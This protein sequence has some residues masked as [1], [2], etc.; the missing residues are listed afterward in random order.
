MIGVCLAG[1]TGWAGSA[2][3]AGIERAPDLELRS[4]VARSSAGEALPGGGRIH[5]DVAAALAAAPVDV[6]IDYTGP[7]AVEGNARAALEAGAG[8]V[9]GSSGL[10]DDT[11]ADLDRLA[12]SRGVGIIASGNFSM[13]AAVMTHAALLAAERVEHFELVE[14]FHDTKPDAPSGSAR[15]LATRLSDVRAP[16]QTVPLD[17]VVGVDGA[18]GAT[19]GAT[20][21]HS[22][23]LP[24]FV[25][26][27]EALFA[28]A[29]ERLVLRYEGGESAE[30]YV[31]GTLI[32]AREVVGRVGLTRG[33]DRLLFP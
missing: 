13:L 8:V 30:P 27:F 1:V 6:L 19:V 18:R 23:R 32:A 21:V 25:A 17:E 7:A 2:V 16:R 28:A 4:G 12:R 14:Y 24:S 26:T 15:E 20:Q 5:G 22:V 31:A 29:G 10:G 11:Y 3:A 33:L 9:I